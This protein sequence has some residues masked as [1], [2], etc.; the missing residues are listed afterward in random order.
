[1]KAAVIVELGL[2]PRFGEFPEPEP[3]EGE[4]VIEVSAAGVHHWDAVKASGSYTPA[5][6]V[7]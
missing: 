3:G 5:T 1:M 2:P 6:A 7:P 4:V